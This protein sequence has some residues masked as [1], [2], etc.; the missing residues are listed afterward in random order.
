MSSIAASPARFC[1]W[2]MCIGN[3]VLYH[4]QSPCYGAPYYVGFYGTQMLSI[5][6]KVKQH[7]CNI[8]IR[9]NIHY[10]SNLSFNLELFRLVPYATTNKS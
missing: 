5:S 8:R 4:C 2:E 3:S 1:D 7:K 9:R 10:L 6:C